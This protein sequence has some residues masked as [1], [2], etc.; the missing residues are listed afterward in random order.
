MQ[1][2]KAH[3]L[4]AVKVI[5]LERSDIVY[6]AEEL[7][8][9]ERYKVETT[10]F[11]SE[12]RVVEK[13]LYNYK[14]DLAVF[15]SKEFYDVNGNL[16]ESIMYG[17]IDGSVKAKSIY[18]YDSDGRPRSYSYN[19]PED[20]V[21]KKGTYIYND[22]GKLLESVVYNQDGLLERKCIYDPNISAN[23]PVTGR[24]YNPDGT[25][26]SGSDR[27][28]DSEGKLI[29]VIYLGANEAF[30]SKTTYIYDSASNIIE[31]AWYDSGGELSSKVVRTFRSQGLVVN[32]TRY[33]SV[34]NIEETYSFTYEFD[35]VGNWIV[36]KMIREASE[37]LPP[38]YRPGVVFYRTISYW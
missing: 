21:I 36:K 12:G 32:E 19:E 13:I 17:P 30:E 15:H 34:S 7:I 26:K 23:E 1:N 18:H 29:E 10:V 27:A 3:F 14:S 35:S 25:V 5:Q 16:L 9:G 6:E 20:V 38:S 11:D 37:D 24:E 2:E 8:E 28:Y 4:G 31:Q 22:A 33:S